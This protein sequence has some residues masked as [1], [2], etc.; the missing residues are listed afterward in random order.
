MAK[1][2]QP[3]VPA[4]RHLIGM[5]G[6]YLVAAEL[7]ARGFI[8]SPTARNAFGA[9]LLVTNQSCSKSFSVQVKA[10]GKRPNFWLLSKKAKQLNCDVHV[11]VLVGQKGDGTG[12][13]Y[14]VV[15]SRVVVD[16]M[17]EKHYKSGVWYSFEREKA[18]K[19][20]DAKAWSVFGIPK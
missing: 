11:Y 17:K 5:R 18:V 6:V 7:S 9:D 12:A 14:F 3:K 16:E 10:S 2:K 1:A 8:V 19:Y 15:P 13:E 20:Q 4:T